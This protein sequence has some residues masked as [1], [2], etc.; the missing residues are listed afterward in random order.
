M[1]S[2]YEMTAKAEEVRNHFRLIAPPLLANSNEF[3]PTDQAMV[4]TGNK[5]GELQAHLMGWGLE[6]NWDN[7]PIINARAE[8]LT[9]KKT[10][11]P[12]LQTRCLVPATGYFEWRKSAAGKL[13]NRIFLEDAGVF[14]FAG[15][16]SSRGASRGDGE[17]FTIITCPPTPAIAHI[18]DRMPVILN[19]DALGPWVDP[20][21]SFGDVANY[22][23]PYEERPLNAIEDTPP[24]PRQSDLFG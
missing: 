24:P 11:Q 4:I 5:N 13:K 12:L 2:R 10:F 19:H 17:K 1:C 23:T 16:F 21:L 22:L 15:L 6:A 14:S 8:T 20:G 7:K 3:R 18:H 9:Q